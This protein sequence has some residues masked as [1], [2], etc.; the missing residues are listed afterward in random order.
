MFLQKSQDWELLNSLSHIDV[1]RPIIAVTKK[2]KKWITQSWIS[3]RHQIWDHHVLQRQK[4]A[5][6]NH[7]NLLSVEEKS[8][9]ARQTK[10][11][12][13]LKASTF[14]F[15]GDLILCHIADAVLWMRMVLV[16]SYIWMLDPQLVGGLSLGR[17]F[18]S[19]R[20]AQPPPPFLLPAHQD[21]KHSAAA[22]VLC[23]SASHHDHHELTLLNCK[24]DPS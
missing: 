11:T 15:S 6:E 16:G 22:P 5:K 12:V 13:L 18:K 14:V 20:Q 24:P 1:P 19:S 17:A 4:G 10:A 23:L 8:M 7:G 2:W 21:V 9:N 3:P